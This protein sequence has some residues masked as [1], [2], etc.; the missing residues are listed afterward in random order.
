[1][2]ILV[3]GSNSQIAK[4]MKEKKIYLQYELIFLSRKECDF[5]NLANLEA[6]IYN[7]KPN[8]CINTS[9]FTQVDQAEKFQVETSI[10]N[11]YAVKKIAEITNKLSIPF[12][13]FSSDY[14]F[15]GEINR[16]YTESDS[17]NPLSVYGLS[18]LN[19]DKE[20]I[21]CNLKHVIIRTSWVVSR[22]NNNFILKILDKLKKNEDINVVNDQFG[23]L[24]SANYL[25]DILYFFINK[26]QNNFKAWG[27]YNICCSGIVS[28]F[29]IALYIKEIYKS[30]NPNSNANIYMVSSE[31]NENRAQRP[32]YSVLDTTKIEILTGI[33]PPFWKD[34]IKKI[35]INDILI[36]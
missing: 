7:F 2:K 5:N 23:R 18:K 19:G 4:T 1:M 12:I 35:L 17:P 16:P 29:D 11:H 28:W 9:A 30:Q 36:R 15:D 32:K 14:I 8:L 34:E 27:I 25:A 24:T 31:I 20:I 6:L 22:Y 33:S 21:N 3:F 13:H 26:I 10:V